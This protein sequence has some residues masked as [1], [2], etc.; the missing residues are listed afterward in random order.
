[1]IQHLS[2]RDVAAYKGAAVSILMLLMIERRPLCQKEMRRGTRYGNDAIHDAVL[3][4]QED[5]LIVRVGNENEYRWA[6]LGDEARQLPLGAVDVIEESASTEG[7]VQNLSDPGPAQSDM[8][9]HVCMHDSESD[10]SYD[11]SDE[12]PT[13]IHGSRSGNSG[14]DDLETA[15]RVFADPGL[16]RLRVQKGLTARVVRYHVANAPGIGAALYRIEHNWHVP[17]DWERDASRT[18]QKYISGEYADAINH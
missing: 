8:G 6:L 1:M 13:C 3:M 16:S 4:L 18:K 12:N 17:D 11:S 2:A 14:P 9:D 15:I 7:D 10:D 5:G